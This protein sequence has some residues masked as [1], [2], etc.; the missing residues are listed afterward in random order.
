MNLV[1]VKPEENH[2]RVKYFR[3]SNPRIK[4]SRVWKLQVAA[5]GL[6]SILIFSRKIANRQP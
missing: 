5:S 1:E 4:A 3:K 6:Y 2:V